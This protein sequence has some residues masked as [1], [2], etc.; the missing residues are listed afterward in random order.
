V[1]ALEGDGRVQR[2]VLENG[3]TIDCDFVVAAIGASLNKEILRAT[4]I[5]TGKLILVDDHLRTSVPGIYAAGDCA[6]VL[7]P[8]F[9][10]HRS[11]DH[12]DNAQVTGA[13]AG[14]NMAGEDAPYAAVNYFFSDVFDLALSAWGESRSVARRLIR[15]T[16]HAASPSFIEIGVDADSRIS[17]VLA[18][19]HASE[20]D[21]LKQLVAGRCA[22]DGDEEAIKD[23]A[24]DLKRLL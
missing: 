22:I 8:L 10:K 1:R 18:I 15:G 17:Q 24:F 21:L 4:P 7:D 14:R 19:N 3:Q 23:P 9:G 11:L 12:W 5:A 20:D 16:T 13:L 6:A 2:A